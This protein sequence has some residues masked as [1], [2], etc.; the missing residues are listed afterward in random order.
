MK[1]AVQ[2]EYKAD[3]KEPFGALLRRVAGAF[4]A[5]GLEPAT[6]ASFSDSIV[7]GGVSATARALK[8]YPEL[9]SFERNESMLPDTATV[10]GLAKTTP[11]Q[12]FAFASIL[13]LADGLPRSLPFYSAQVAFGH[14]LFGG[15]ADPSMTLVRLSG[16]VA[17][18]TWWVNGRNRSLSAAYVVEGSSRSKTLTSPPPAVAAVLSALGKPKKS[19]QFLLPQDEASPDTLAQTAA[20][21]PAAIAVSAIVARY[22]AGMAAMVGRLELPHTLLPLAP[23][24][25]T[26][27]AAGP[28]KP[29]LT[30]AF[31][32]RGYD[33]RGESG[34]FTLRRR[35]RSNH[36]V[37]LVIDVG[38][39]S[40]MV[41]PSYRV[42]GPGFT[43]NLAI[44]VTAN[45]MGTLQYP[46]GDQESWKR[47]V[48]NLAVIFDE[49]D[50]TLLP[51]IE[52]A[53]GPA[54][55]WF[56]PGR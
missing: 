49:L 14:E 15:N 22:R 32:P 4:D 10:R 3:R 12:P 16:I 45:L 55:D 53:V 20:P 41:T 2:L 43:A 8:K 51:E 50:R 34:V 18:D 39:W 6:T 33:C 21:P 28:L 7:G 35:T 11:D 37:D 9:Q 17:S 26:G 47:I 56:E 30:A 54:P 46:I 23:A 40:R 29:A 38:T 31:G 44:P 25:H 1:I 5:A 19:A 13:A 24:L 48:A 36:V 52:T 27:A 42:Q